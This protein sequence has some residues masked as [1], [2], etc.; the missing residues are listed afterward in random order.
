[1]KHHVNLPE[2]L[3][4]SAPWLAGLLILGTAALSAAPGPDVQREPYRLDTGLVCRSISFENPTGAPGQGGQAAS[5][6]GPGRK[7]APARDI[8]PGET[9]QLC[10]VEGPGTL[11]HV[12]M[13]TSGEPAIQRECVI[14]AYWEGQEHPSLE[15]PIGDLF[16]FAHGKIM[17]YQSAVHSCGPTG[18][19]NLWLGMP[20]TRRARLTFTNEG[21][22]PVPLFYQITYTLKDRHPR[23]VGRLHVLFR[24]ENPTTE[25]ADFELL[26]RRAQKGRFLGSIIGIRNLHP[27][28]WWGEGEIK[29]YMDGDKEWPTIV[30]TGSEDYVGLAWGIQQASFLFNGCSLN[31][32]NFV[33]MYR[34]HLADPIAWERE[35]RITIQQIAWKDGLKETQDDWSCATFWYEP[36]PSAPLPPL[37]DVQARTADIWK[38]VKP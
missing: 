17:S 12:W 14:R 32:K 21:K 34:W 13:T 1:M 19:R 7:G 24:R 8:K 37:P 30:G 4:S 6:L 10:D 29:V 20:F 33:S 38:D 3:P 27:D 22:Q 31:E 28:Q 36:V 11:R 16:G 35:A 5:N 25:K 26:P 15:C 23:D 18:G 9:V 2:L